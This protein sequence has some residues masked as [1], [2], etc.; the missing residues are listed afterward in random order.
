MGEPPAREPV[1]VTSLCSRG[2]QAAS[3]GARP[4]KG[5]GVRKR[6]NKTMDTWGPP[7]DGRGERWKVTREQPSLGILPRRAALRPLLCTPQHL[8]GVYLPRLP[9]PQLAPGL[10]RGPLWAARQLGRVTRSQSEEE[11]PDG[12]SH[13][14]LASVS[15][16]S[17]GAQSQHSPWSQES[18]AEDSAARQ[19]WCATDA[20]QQCVP[21]SSR[22]RRDQSSGPAETGQAAD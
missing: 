4:G 19:P 13:G 2:Q 14:F 9:T 10:A 15:P 1:P 6:G 7:G 18:A 12:T 5:E 17:G 8:L 22:L 16:S 20:P 11:R 3:T 21:R